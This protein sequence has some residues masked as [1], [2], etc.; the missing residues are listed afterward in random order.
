MKPMLI[1]FLIGVALFVLGGSGL[2]RKPSEEKLVHAHAKEPVQVLF[3]DDSPE[4]APIQVDFEGQHYVL[5]PRASY[6]IE[7]LIVSQ[8]RSDSIFDLMH[9]RTGDS[10]NLRDI[11]TVWGHTLAGGAY[12]D[13]RFWSGDWTCYYQFSD[14]ETAAA[15]KPNELSN[16]H[17]LATD[18]G[19]RKKLAELETGDEYRMRGKLVDYEMTGLGLRRTSLVRTDTDN[20]ACE[21]M[22]VESVEILRSHNRLFRLLREIGFWIAFSMLLLIAARMLRAIFFSPRVAIILLGACL[23]TCLVLGSQTAH[24]KLCNPAEEYC[25]DSTGTSS[26]TSSASRGTKIRINPAILSVAKGFGVET[27]YFDSS[28]DFAL[29]SGLG[30]VGAAISPSN[31]EETFFGPPGIE[32]PTAL[33]ERKRGHHKFKAPKYTLATAVNIFDNRRS[34][35]S[36]FA[37]NL[38]VM[39]KYHQPTG[40]ITPGG[41]LS[42]VAGPVNIGFSMYSD[43]LSIGDPSDGPTYLLYRYNVTTYSVGAFIGPL[44][45][46]YSFLRVLESGDAT[47]SLITGTWIFKRALATVAL[48]T[49]KILRPT[50]NYETDLLE[51]VEHKDEYFAGLQV[52]VANPVLVGVFYNYYLVRDISFGLTLFF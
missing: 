30:R 16:T 22:Y 3:K 37:L 4:A 45:I 17:V 12:R 5:R 28:F 52:Q 23:N 1:T 42:A 47:V 40:N 50:Y 33:L 6:S 18:P 8:H 51:L 32:D 14:A 43:E 39:G 20:G 46:D 27:L 13:V 25:G 15:F 34:G 48:R 7:G 36:R 21:V 19:V 41:G 38:G 2:E 49:E 35:M 10:L 29:V 9:A 44:A 11:C 24:A 31:S 26:P